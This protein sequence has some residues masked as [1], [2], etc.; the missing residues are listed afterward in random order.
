MFEQTNWL[1]HTAYIDIPFQWIGWIG[2]FVMLGAL[3]WGTRTYWKQ[4][5]RNFRLNWIWAVGLAIS[6]PWCG[7]AL[8]I[9]VSVSS[10]MPVPNLPVESVQPVLI[11]FYALPMILAAGFLGPLGSMLIGAFSGLTL[12][13]FGSH[14][15]FSVLETAIIGWLI[16]EAIHQNYS[17]RF[18]RF[19]RHPIGA[20]LIIALVA[21]PIY[22]FSAF[23]TIPGTL[24]ERMDFAITQN[25][26]KILARGTE[27]VL[28]GGIAE[29]IY[30]I[31]P[32]IWVRP[33]ELRPGPTETSLQA[34]FTLTTLPIIAVLL[35]SLIV[36]DWLV[37]GQAAH[38][39]IQER[40][41]NTAKIAS[42]SVPYF[43]EIGQSLITD[44]ARPDLLTY[45]PE[46]MQNQ[47]SER[48]RNVPYF[49]QF[50]LFD[51]ALNLLAGYPKANLDQFR[52]T[53][54]EQ[55]GLNL[56]LEG[57][58]VQTYAVPP[59]SGEQSAQISFIAAI[60]NEQGESLGVV[61]GRTDLESNPFTQPA[62]NALDAI[63]ADGGAS[64]IIDEDQTV[65]FQALPGENSEITD[66]YFG[67]V[68]DSESFFEDV[69]STGTRQLV[70]YQ[71]VIGRS[72]AV[73]TTMPAKTA[74]E[75][76]LNIAIPLLVI[77][78]LLFLISVL[79]IRGN[80][81]Q[82][83]SKLHSLA[84]QARQI[85]AGGLDTPIQVSGVDE[86]GVLGSSFE[87]MR[88][89]L[90]NR[91]D[92]QT[93]LLEVS[94]GVAAHL[95]VS[96]A[97][98]PILKAALSEN[99]CAVRVTLIPD[100]R[101]DI[102][103]EPL[104]GIGTGPMAEDYAYLDSQIFELMRTQEVLT[105]SNIARIR[106]IIN[107]AGN[108]HPLALIAFALRFEN[109]YF[110]SLWIGFDQP[111]AFTSDEV[112][113]FSML[114]NE[115]G[116]A[117]ANARLYAA[118]EIG[119]RRFEAVL[120]ST[121]EPVLVFDQNDRL[122]LLNPATLH[123]PG[124]INSSTPGKTVSEVLSSPDLIKLVSGPADDRVA[125]QEI[126]LSNGRVY[127]G[128]IAPVA[129]EDFLL[130]KVCVLRDITHYKEL[131]TI[132]SDFVATVSHDL[133]TPLTLMRGYTT[134]V[135]MV[136]DLNEQQKSYVNKM[137]SGVENMTHLVNNLLDL[138]RIEAGISLN[139]EEITPDVVIEKIIKQYYPQAAQKNIS[140]TFE[141]LA[142][143]R[144]INMVADVD[145][146]QQA[147]I[148]LVDNAIKYTKSNGSVKIKLNQRDDLVI[149]E[150][151]DSG[152]GIAPLDMPRL[153]ERFYR[154]GRREAFEQRG[155]GLGLAIVKTIVERH[156]GR[157]FV[158][159]QLGKG[160]S[161][162]M[163]FPIKQT[164]VLPI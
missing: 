160:S 36:T 15:I 136:G 145:L 26:F 147:L 151:H 110:G 39:M 116:L 64:Y 62:L 102:S 1:K 88:V 143:G 159:S 45:D 93:K 154:S 23:F 59:V 146:L 162:I 157:I 28:A 75:V 27:L 67:R 58:L 57:V 91:M 128:S 155:T 70:F 6:A 3:I 21:I 108:P 98:T 35:I 30:L 119:R 10:L 112:R 152:I 19:L 140:L 153:F 79:F 72:W 77:L 8:T 60:L 95:Q 163:E 138:G 55:S 32:R 76:A 34:R 43:L 150:V 101:M 126:H 13:V 142:D 124:L 24:A 68:S 16:G 118:A 89:S 37:A 81:G 92:E 161:F 144:R 96:D 40:L 18:Y 29:V 73:I 87:Q 156:H 11:P 134:M 66:Q 122:L 14:S 82:L 41:S 20:A 5:I 100:V 44:M 50:Y 71:P 123:V 42:E 131:D 47:L 164:K 117:A 52:L 132:K 46:E 133:R 107:T 120:N 9:N 90:K 85:A 104:L 38:Q 111:K 74:Q 129:G 33:Q 97:I 2:W 84:G 130:G 78:L 103:S 4:A 115:A 53:A 113:F 114:A 80:L 158:E 139:L 54:E 12:A 25:W 49:R 17:S 125:S 48:I 137:V 121:P 31:L 83:A 22:L 109:T 69:S 105:I 51:P 127:Q 149:F 94:Q 63:A 56:A 135:S 148:N 99:A 61:L 7:F 106:R 141:G 86:I 65:L